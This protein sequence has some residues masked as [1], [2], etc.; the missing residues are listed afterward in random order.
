MASETFSTRLN[1]VIRARG[2]T[3]RAAAELCTINYHTLNAVLTRDN[4]VPNAQIALQIADGLGVRLEWLVAGRQGPDAPIDI[5]G[6]VGLGGKVDGRDESS[7]KAVLVELPRRLLHKK[8]SALLVYGDVL[9]PFFQ[10]GDV[11]FFEKDPENV[12][13]AQIDNRPHLVRD[14]SGKEWIKSVRVCPDTGKLEA[15]QIFQK[16]STAGRTDIQFA[17]PV[18][19]AMSGSMVDLVS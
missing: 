9:E 10:P 5:V 17:V 16:S 2:L 8:L 7:A 19:L 6:I 18:L 4:A 1:E 13:A 14:H 11:L 12:Y 15:F 3:K